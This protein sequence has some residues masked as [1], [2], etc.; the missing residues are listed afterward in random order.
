MKSVPFFRERLAG[1]TYASSVAGYMSSSYTTGNFLTM[2]ILTLLRWDELVCSTPQ[3]IIVGMTGNAVLMIIMAVITSMNRLGDNVMF[4]ILMIFTT[5]SGALTALM[6]KGLFGM[7]ARFPPNLTPG[8]LTG[9][10]AAGLLV[11][12]AN[13]LTSVLGKEAHSA[14]PIGTILYFSIGA[15]ILCLSVT[16]FIANCRMSEY[17]R[18]RLGISEDSSNL[19][20]R[21]PND[22]VKAVFCRI[23]WFAIGILMTLFVTISLFATFITSPR[24]NVPV[25]SWI[26]TFYVPIIFVIY[27]FGDVIGRWLPGISLFGLH[28]KS[29]LI[30]LAPWLRLVI[31]IP[32]FAFGAPVNIGGGTMPSTPSFTLGFSDLSYALLTF[33]FGMS[34]GYCCTTLLMHAPSLA[35][36]KHSFIAAPEEGSPD[37]L[38]ANHEPDACG[39]LMA[40]FLNIGLLLGALSSFIW[41]LIL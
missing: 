32:L 40:L 1:A 29:R 21:I 4:G 14:D 22:I 33:T 19:K 11:S 39:A 34:T 9:Q 28:P 12:T 37:N 10:A 30:C 13:V 6:M 23:K 2:L 18:D 5:L 25:D 8:L 3:R 16:T 26:A 20:S 36:S 15:A 24:R 7:A 38:S 31:F 27:D 35:I 17:F 41:Q